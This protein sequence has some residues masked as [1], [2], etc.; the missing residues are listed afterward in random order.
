MARKTRTICL[1]HAT[2]VENVESI[3]KLGIL[4]GGEIG[5]S[6]ADWTDERAVYLGKKDG[7]NYPADLLK[8]KTA[9]FKVCIPYTKKTDLFADNDWAR[10]KAVDEGNLDEEEWEE[11]DIDDQDDFA[12]DWESSVDDGFGARFIGSIPPEWITGCEIGH[13][14]DKNVF[15]TDLKCTTD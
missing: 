2:P 14:D 4:P 5:K 7:L 1:Y 13:F 10:I 11:M 12:F 3:K 8:L 6:N 15:V 9:M